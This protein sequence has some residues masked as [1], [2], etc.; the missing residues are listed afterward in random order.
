MKVKSIDYYSQRNDEH[1]GFMTSARGILEKYPSADIDI[2]D[3]FIT[4]LKEAVD[5][6]DLSYKIVK[7]SS[8]TEELSKL[9]AVSDSILVGFTA[10]VRS[11]ITHYE[12][13]CQSAAN[14]IMIEY[15]AFGDIRNKSY[16]AQ[17][18]DIVNLLQVLNGKL[19]V[20]IELLGLQGWVERIEEAN[21]LFME[22]FNA[23][24]EEKAEKDSITRLKKCRAE[25]DD[26]YRAIVD[27]LNAGIVFFGE[28]KY[29]AIVIELN[30]TIDYY[31][32]LTA[33]RRGRAAAK[34]KQ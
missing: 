16:V 2:P 22:T 15:K 5:N 27:R 4:R 20:D 12:P 14:R 23:R 3:A 32:N 34:K 33:Q 19:K 28:D 30:V 1:L 10:Q 24:N 9:D 8:L 13:A 25:T 31:N 21:N 11:F 26:A 18:T 7:K 29:K 6:E 17:A